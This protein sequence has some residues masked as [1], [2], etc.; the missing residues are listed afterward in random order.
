MNNDKIYLLYK[1]ELY[2]FNGIIWEKSNNKLHD[3]LEEIIEHFRHYNYNVKPSKKEIQKWWDEVF[4]GFVLIKLKR[5]YTINFIKFDNQHHKIPFKNGKLNLRNNKFS[6][7]VKEDYL[8][9][10]LDFEYNEV[11]NQVLINK[12]HQIYIDIFSDSEQTPDENKQ[13]I[14]EV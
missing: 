8:T 9:V 12:Y 4:R 1:S 7:I 6:P 10:T 3:K 13:I 11:V 5:K 14:E 2:C